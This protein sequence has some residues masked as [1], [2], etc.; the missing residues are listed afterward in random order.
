METNRRFS[1]EAVF[2][3]DLKK[4]EQD[5]YRLICGVV[6]RLDRKSEGSEK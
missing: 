5:F 3:Q 6:K 2:E 1:K 4:S